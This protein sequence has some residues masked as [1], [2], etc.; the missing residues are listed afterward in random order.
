M[1]TM[2]VTDFKA[3]ALQVISS[4]AKTHEDIVITKRGKPLV[5]VVPFRSPFRAPKPGKLA[6]TLVA[7]KDILSPWGA[8]LWKSAR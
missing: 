3:H 6:H 4:V 2:A 5:E 7:E 8:S 1:R